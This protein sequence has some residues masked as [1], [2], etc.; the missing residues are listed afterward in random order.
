MRGGKEHTGSDDVEHVEVVF[1]DEAVEVSID[2][3]EA[4]TCTPVTE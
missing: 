3:C 1:D 2:E 4:W